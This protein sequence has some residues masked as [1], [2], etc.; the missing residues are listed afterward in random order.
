[1]IE[2]FANILYTYYID[3]L[4]YTSTCNKLC[5]RILIRHYKIITTTI[6]LKSADDRS[7]LFEM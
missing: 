5:I 1:M 7:A 2:Q 3:T 6:T 4:S